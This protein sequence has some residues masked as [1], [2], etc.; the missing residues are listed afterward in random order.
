LSKLRG[1]NITPTPLHY[2]SFKEKL[3]ILARP[4]KQI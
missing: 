1:L 2:F 3:F 4:R